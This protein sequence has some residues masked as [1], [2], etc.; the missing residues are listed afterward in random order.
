[1]QGLV[2]EC[3]GRE[4]APGK[5]LYAISVRCSRAAAVV[6]PKCRDKARERFFQLFEVALEIHWRRIEPLPEL[7]G[8]LNRHGFGAFQAGQM[9]RRLDAKV[10][11]NGANIIRLRQ[12]PPVDLVW[13]CVLEIIFET[14]PDPLIHLNDEL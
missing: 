4:S 3:I 12:R 14:T 5:F 2:K 8:K 7:I 9:P 11:Q 10:S 1:V 6:A 13:R